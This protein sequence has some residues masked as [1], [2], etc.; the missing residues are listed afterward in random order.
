MEPGYVQDC[1]V[2][3]LAER[4]EKL[5]VTHLVVPPVAVRPS[6]EMDS[7]AGRWVIFDM[8]VSTLFSFLPF[9]VDDSRVPGFQLLIGDLTPLYI[10]DSLCS[11][12]CL[13]CQAYLY[14]GT[15]ICA[16]IWFQQ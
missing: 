2:L 1:E 7:A 10:L 6:V 5:I 14:G 13:T 9:N 11:L 3:D 16:L 15:H 8:N 12:K 4:P